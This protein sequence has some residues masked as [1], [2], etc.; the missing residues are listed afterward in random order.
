MNVRAAGLTLAAKVQEALAGFGRGFLSCF[1]RIN[2]ATAAL[3]HIACLPMSLSTITFT[4]TLSRPKLPV[5][6]MRLAAEL[7]EGLDDPLDFTVDCDAAKYA[8]KHRQRKRKRG[9]GAPAAAD[10]ATAAAD[11]DESAAVS[12]RFRYQLPLKR[13]GKSV[14]LFHNGSVHATGC[15]SPLE[16]L[17]MMDALRGFIS[18][19]GGEQTD[20]WLVDFDIQLINTLFLVTDP[21]T[22]RPLTIAPGALLRRLG[23]ETRAD[24]DTERHPS[25]K[26]PLLVD[27]AKA[28]TVCV[29]QTGSVSIMGAKRPEHVAA[30]YEMVCAALDACAPEVCTADRA[31]RVRTT[32]AKQPLVL[33]EGYPFNLHACCQA[34]DEEEEI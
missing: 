34:G 17:E 3:R 15:T 11:A 33:V 26:I 1:E 2:R 6:E 31:A 27:G 14:K 24:F 20:A 8:A 5:D 4:G 30:A 21:A 22:G 25:V 13:N 19:A 18:A 28:A 9:G 29:F 23:S 16:F 32:T 10:A 12:K 7:A